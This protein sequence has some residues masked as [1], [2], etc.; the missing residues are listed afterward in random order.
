M[1][2][3]SNKLKLSEGASLDTGTTS[4]H[5][6]MLITLLLLIGAL[7]LT[8][9]TMLYYALDGRPADASLRRPGPAAET[10]PPADHAPG[11]AARE[12]AAGALSGLLSR[13]SGSVRWPKLKLS[14]FGTSIDGTEAFAIIN[15]R[16]YYPGDMI[17][18]KAT[19]IEVRAQDV[20]LEYLG[21]TKT[22]QVE[23]PKH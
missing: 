20:V 4:P 18:G 21:E 8:G 19:L 9:A 17:E 12:P 22:L 5:G 2:E 16:T 23:L 7:L 15:N 6:V 14:G 10:A 1:S 11:S 13:P 3:P